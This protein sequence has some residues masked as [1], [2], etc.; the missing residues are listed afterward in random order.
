MPRSD[1]DWRRVGGAH[2]IA[3]AGVILIFL[4]APLVLT[5]EATAVTL[6]ICLALAHATLTML[7]LWPPRRLRARVAVVHAAAEATVGVVLVVA[8]LVLRWSATSRVFFGMVGLA[9]L[10]TWWL[11]DY[12]SVARW[13]PDPRRG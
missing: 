4:V 1:A 2:L 12:R 3:D 11:T 8:S 6:A 7:V 13:S 5:M 9:I 10:L